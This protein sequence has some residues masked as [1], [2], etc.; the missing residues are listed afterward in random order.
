MAVKAKDLYPSIF[1]R[2]AEAYERRLDQVMTTGEARGRLR[3][4]ELVDAKPG[5][6][7]LDMACGPG[8][9]TLRIAP[10]VEPNGEVL[11]VDLAPGM[12][13][14]ARMAAVPNARFEIMDIEDLQLADGSFDGAV[15]GHGLQFVPHLGRALTEA[16]R[17]LRPGSRFAASVPGGPGQGQTV[18][19]LLDSV[20][21]R[22][23]PPAPQA[24]DRAA[25]QAAV[26]DPDAFRLAAIAAGFATARVEVITETVRW[27]SADQLVALCSGWWVCASRLDGLDP[28]RRDDFI[29]DALNTLRNEHP[30]PIETSSGN[31][32]LF[33]TTA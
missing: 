20:V 13:E 27:E 25:T 12:I 2:H 18:M 16:R 33:A 28:Q 26:G 30:G 9:L 1:S 17:V 23:L 31:H 15:C 4:I 10:L 32:V 5:M 6:R 21:E 19:R 14:R 22:W 8:V 29:A 24:D 11:G 7:I 3:V